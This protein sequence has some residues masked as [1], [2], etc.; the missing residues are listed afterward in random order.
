MLLAATGVVALFFLGLAFKCLRRPAYA[1]ALT[2]VMYPFE[3][4]L[5]SQFPF[6]IAHRSFMNIFT[7]GIVGL[8][9]AGTAM[10]GRRLFLADRTAQRGGLGARKSPRGGHIRRRVGGGRGRGDAR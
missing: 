3:Q 10:R 1:F 2:A 4:L 9:V 5:Q 8:A 7:A 6:F